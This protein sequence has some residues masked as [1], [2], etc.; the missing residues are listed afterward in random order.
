M[1]TINKKIGPSE[2]SLK[3]IKGVE[4]KIQ[5]MKAGQE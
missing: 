4:K 5:Q 3:E 1:P 2:T